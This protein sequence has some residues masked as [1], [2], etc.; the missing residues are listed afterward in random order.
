MCRGAS[1]SPRRSHQNR[2]AVKLMS[3]PE[4]K[5]KELRRVCNYLHK[6]IKWLRSE[7]LPE[8]KIRAR[9]GSPAIYC[10]LSAANSTAERGPGPNVKINSSILRRKKKS[11]ASREDRSHDA[12][13]IL[14]PGHGVAFIASCINKYDYCLV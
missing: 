12:A 13:I 8:Q 1:C 6:A 3:S 4:V 9:N 7:L 10:V 14:V 5:C 2:R 11:F